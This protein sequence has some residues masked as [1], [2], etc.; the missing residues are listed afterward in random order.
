MNYWVDERGTWVTADWF[1]EGPTILRAK[2]KPAYIWQSQT[3]NDWKKSFV[4]FLIIIS[5]ND[6][7]Q[8]LTNSGNLAIQPTA[9]SGT[10]TTQCRY[11]VENVEGGFSYSFGHIIGLD[12]NIPEPRSQVELQDEITFYSGTDLEWSF[13]LKNGR[14]FHVEETKSAFSVKQFHFNLPTE[15]ILRDLKRMDFDL[16]TSYL[17][18]EKWWRVSV[19]EMT[20]NSEKPR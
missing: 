18:L 13:D 8:L 16:R 4:P 14:V 10:L 12:K 11:R 17:K 9:A 1:V 19:Q 7:F 3:C 2:G 6:S 15:I 20:G 5:V